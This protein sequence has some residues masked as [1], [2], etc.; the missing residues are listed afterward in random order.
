MQ[1]NLT[2]KLKQITSVARQ[3]NKAIWRE[4]DKEGGTERGT[5]LCIIWSMLGDR[6]SQV[7]SVINELEL[8][9]LWRRIRSETP[10]MIQPQTIYSPKTR[11]LIQQCEPLITQIMLGI[12]KQIE[13]WVSYSFTY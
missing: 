2:L 9:P 12:R 6:I 8:W 1:T 3:L 7:E 10:L 13:S 11:W 4:Y 5:K